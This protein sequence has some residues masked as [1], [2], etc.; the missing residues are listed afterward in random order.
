MKRYPRTM[1][2]KEQDK[3][4]K[5]DAKAAEESAARRRAHRERVFRDGDAS[6]IPIPEDN[7]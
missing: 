5:A 7:T 2:T 1:S 6:G 3:Q 4:R